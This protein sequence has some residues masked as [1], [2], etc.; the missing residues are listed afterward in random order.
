MFELRI[1]NGAILI[2]IEENIFKFK[3]GNKK[4]SF[5]ENEMVYRHPFEL[6]L[7]NI[8]QLEIPP[9]VARREGL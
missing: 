4:A 7:G 2:G 3:V 6:G 5:K 8:Y 1:I 9:W